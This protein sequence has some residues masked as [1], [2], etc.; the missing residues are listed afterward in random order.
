MESKN[1][2]PA[3][4]DWLKHTCKNLP[5]KNSSA[6]L[7]NALSGLRVGE[8]FQSVHLIRTDLD[9]YMNKDKM[10][11]EHYKYRGLF[12][13]RTK[14]AYIS[15]LTL[16][17]LKLCLKCRNVGENALR[18]A[19]KRRN[20]HDHFKYCRKIYATHLR[21]EG[22][23]A[24]R[25]D[26]L[27]GRFPKSVFARHYLRPDMDAEFGKVRKALESLHAEIHADKLS[28]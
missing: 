4:L 17:I 21:A 27:Q 18:H 24:E 9:N 14:K 13:R 15:V 6:V 16:R 2:Y 10:P 28:R 3:M 22:I 19:I 5:N 26:L 11:L 8:L 25:L 12:I 20:L 23:S 7:F 1:Q